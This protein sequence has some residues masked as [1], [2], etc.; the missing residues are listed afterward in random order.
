SKVIFRS[1]EKKKIIHSNT[2]YS[3]QENKHCER[4]VFQEGDL[5]WIHMRKERFSAGRFEKFKPGIGGPF[6]VQKKINDN[7]YKI[8]ILGCYNV[9]IIFN[10]SNLS[11]YSEES[12]DEENSRMSFSQAGEDDAGALDRNV[13][14]VE[15][16]K[17]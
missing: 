13:N 14:L 17:L 8:E 1:K 7:A 10:V 9:S 2:H 4:V 12:E 11:P 5:V 6:Q 3:A 16:L 15:Y